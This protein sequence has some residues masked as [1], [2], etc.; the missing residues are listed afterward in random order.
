M[1]KLIAAFFIIQLVVSFSNDKK[2][3]IGLLTDPSTEKKISI[4]TKKALSI[5]NYKNHQAFLDAVAYAE[6]R[7][8]YKI[9]NKWGYLGKYQFHPNTLRSLKIKVT[10]EEFLNNPELQEFA[11]NK[12]LEANKRSLR[13]QVKKYSEQEVYGVYVTE[14]GILAAAHLAG[15]GNVRK[16]FRTGTNFKDGLGT[17]ITDYMENFGGYS[18]NIE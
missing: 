13:R 8:N 15:A 12:L 10:P 5:A 11:M 1:R 18:L 6:S 17:S 16:W 2:S 3:N 9:V 4:A 7:C 14:S